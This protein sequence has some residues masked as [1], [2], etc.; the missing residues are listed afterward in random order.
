M[1]AGSEKARLIET[2]K[3]E[4]PFL[5]YTSD[6]SATPQRYTPSIN[7]F[8]AEDEVDVDEGEDRLEYV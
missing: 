1:A 3:V 6:S 7:D 4:S 2:G 5:G 8:P